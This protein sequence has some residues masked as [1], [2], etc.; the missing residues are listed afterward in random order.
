MEKITASRLIKELRDLYQ[1]KCKP[2]AFADGV[3][4]AIIFGNLI[5]IPPC[6]SVSNLE[7]EYQFIRHLMLQDDQNGVRTWRADDL[8]EGFVT[9]L[10]AKGWKHDTDKRKAQHQQR[11]I[12]DEDQQ[13]HRTGAKSQDRLP[14]CE[15]A[16]G[17]GR[18]HVHLQCA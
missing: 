13:T 16:E 8:Y 12:R 10:N 9:W 2:H 14:L 17:I 1:V 15:Q 6:A 7:Y 4:P 11:E 3:M 18:Q 5:V